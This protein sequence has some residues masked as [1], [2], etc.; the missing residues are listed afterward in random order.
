MS[1]TP[2]SVKTLLE[3]AD[4]GDRLSGLNQLRQLDPAIAYEL[5]QAP[6]TDSNVRVR[7]AAISQLA[8]LGSQNRDRTLT[9]LKAALNDSEADVQAAAADSVGALKL[10]DAYEDLETLYRNTPEWL[11]RFSVLA[12]LGELGDRRA[13][14]LLAEALNSDSELE[15]NAAIGSLGELGDERAVDLLIPFATNPD[16]QVRHRIVQA[17]SVYNSP[18]ARSTLETLSQDEA[19]QVAEQ[20][21][22]ALK[23]A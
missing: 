1:I 4:Y 8:T 13:F 19:E 21:R 5:I 16:W 3:S 10:S 6:I 17:L 23:G 20:A 7:Y 2:E 14:D 9:I 12:T 11:V 15:Q 18:A 22:F